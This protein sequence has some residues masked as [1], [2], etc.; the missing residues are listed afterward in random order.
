VLFAATLASWE[1]LNRVR[2]AHYEDI[3][4]RSAHYQWVPILQDTLVWVAAF[5]GLALLVALVR[6]F[7]ERGSSSHHAEHA[8][9]PEQV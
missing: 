5:L 3:F 2:V 1:L 4:V 9:T 7:V 8:S 6:V